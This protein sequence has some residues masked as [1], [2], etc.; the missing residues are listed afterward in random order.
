MVYMDALTTAVSAPA[1][2]AARAAL[3]NAF[4]AAG[5]NRAQAEGALNTLSDPAAVSLYTV[6][7][8]DVLARVKV[9][10][11]ALYAANDAVISTRRSIPEA[12]LALRGNPDA[13]VIEV[14]DVNHGF[15]QLESEASG[16]SEYKGWPISDPKTL[17]LIDQWLAK[18]LLRAGHD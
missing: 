1:V 3:G 13:T 12:R 10:I 17:N 15:Q 8:N 9:P 5:W 7:A 4:V 6:E 2:P 16:K 11:L 18:R 14:P